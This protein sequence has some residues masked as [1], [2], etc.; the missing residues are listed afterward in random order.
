MREPG[1][2][3]GCLLVL[4]LWFLFWAGVV[5]FCWRVFL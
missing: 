3:P 2:S 5:L 1:P 4:A